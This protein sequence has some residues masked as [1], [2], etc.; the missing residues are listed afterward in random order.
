MILDESLQLGD[1]AFQRKC[2]KLLFQERNQ[3]TT[4]LVTHDIGAKS[5]N[6]VTRLFLVENGLVKAISDLDVSD[7]YSYVNLESN[8]HHN[9]NEDEEKLVTAEVEGFT[10]RLSFLLRERS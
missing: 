2:N 9:G 4:I 7:Q 6:I 1:D 10:A 8:S 5:R 3:E